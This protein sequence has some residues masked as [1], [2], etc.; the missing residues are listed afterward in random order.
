[1]HAATAIKTQSDDALR[2][3]LRNLVKLQSGPKMLLVQVKHGGNDGGFLIP[4]VGPNPTRSDTPA[5]FADNMTALISRLRGS[6]IAMGYDPKNLM[7]EYGAYHPK[8]GPAFDDTGRTAVERL[9]DWESA[10]INLSQQHPEYNLAVVRGSR[11]TTPL[12]M[13]AN[14][15][16]TSADDHAHLSIDGYV[17]VPELDVRQVVSYANP[18]EVQNRSN[19]TSLSFTFDS[20]VSAELSPDDLALRESGSDA[21]IDPFNFAVDWDAATK[22][23]TW[24]FQGLPLGELPAGDYE[25]TV[26]LAQLGGATGAGG[27]GASGDYVFNFTAEPI[28]IPEPA[29]LGA[30]TLLMLA[31]LRR[32]AVKPQQ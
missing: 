22:T 1:V 14:G 18:D 9:A 2:E 7:F 11:L 4:S 26:R 6:W 8:E 17:G 30:L 20:D 3:Y 16:Y 19:V 31:T 24:T 10:I 27:G 29:A 28:A 13:A 25:A 15:W 21:L 32:R 5:G 23:A 12:T